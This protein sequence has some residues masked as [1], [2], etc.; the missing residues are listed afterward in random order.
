MNRKPTIQMVA[1]LAGVS[2]GTVDRVLNNRPHVNDEARERVLEAMRK[3]GYISPRENYRRQMDASLSPI[4]LGVL[5]PNWEGQFRAEVDRGI[6]LACG[7]LEETNV[8]VL[9]RRCETDLPQEAVELL[10]TMRRGGAAGFAVC[11]VN[12]PAI[13]TWIAAR[14]AEGVPCVTFN[15]DLPASGRLCFVGQD[16]RQAGRLA[17]GLLYKCVGGQGPI[18]ATAGNLKFDGHRQRLDGFRE[19]LEEL[20]FPAEQLIVRETY[21]DYETSVRVVSEALEE[22]P[23]LQGVYMANLSVAGCCAAIERAE[24]KGRVHVVCHDINEGI[25]QL[26]RSGA[27]D[28]TIP[29]NLERQGYAPLLLLRD[30]LRKKKALEPGRVQ[31]RIDILCAENLESI[32]K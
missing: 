4:T 7:E 20:G 1:D 26:V 18:L 21:N 28:F 22:Q 15:S 27:V 23:D 9:L 31:S 10:E 32:P 19:R 29:Q 12:D 3:L 25:R 11:A 17:A 8:R 2:R 14:M 6:R 13:E 24:R 16:I 30:Y 5:L